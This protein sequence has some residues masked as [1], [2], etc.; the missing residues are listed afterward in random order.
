MHTLLWEKICKDPAEHSSFVAAAFRILPQEIEFCTPS[1]A[2]IFQELFERLHK[3]KS[4]GR[5]ESHPQKTGLLKFK[6]V[7]EVRELKFGYENSSQL[8]F[9]N[10]S[11]RI[12]KGDFIG[13]IGGSGSG[14]TSLV[15]LILGLL[16]PKSGEILV[17]GVD[18]RDGIQSWQRLLG[19][20][21]QEIYLTDNSVRENIAFG[22]PLDQVEEARVLR[23]VQLA[24][25]EV[26]VKSLPN[27]L[28]TALGERGARLSG[29]Q[30]Q[31]IGIARALY[32]DRKFV[33][34]KRLVHLI[35]RLKVT[36]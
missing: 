18:I 8:V 35:L 1:R 24:H 32:A 2:S 21:P 29:G 34:D 6:D 23:A 28:D 7:I 14:K 5:I 17:D 30:R 12:K 36:S 19:Y 10:F 33:L 4:V 16:N 26:I 20:V 9:E 15:D 11:L 22:V 13:I 3:E 31:R 27:G 25:L